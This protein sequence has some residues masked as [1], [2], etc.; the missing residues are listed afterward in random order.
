MGFPYPPEAW[1]LGHR[2]R[3][4]PTCCLPFQRVGE[5]VAVGHGAVGFGEGVGLVLDAK[6]GEVFAAG[7]FQGAATV[8]ADAHNSAFADRELLTI[9]LI[10]A[11]S[12]QDDVKLFMGFVCV[13]EPAV[14]SRHEGLERE[15]AAGGSH[16]LS[17]EDLALDY[18][19]SHGQLVVDNLIDG[20]YAY[21]LVVAAASDCFNCSHFVCLLFV[22]DVIVFGCK[23]TILSK[24]PQEDTY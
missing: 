16:G 3:G 8:G 21:C 9:H 15:F 22:N 10:G 13:E 11:L 18:G 5:D 4:S 2:S 24:T 6:H 1:A 19:R 12:T 17:Y 20:S 7:V 23:N 14:L